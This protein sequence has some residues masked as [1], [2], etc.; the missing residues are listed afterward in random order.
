MQRDVD[1]VEKP[2]SSPNSRPRFR[3]RRNRRRS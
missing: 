2:I 1:E 3:L